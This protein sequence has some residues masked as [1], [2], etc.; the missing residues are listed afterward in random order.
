MLDVSQFD[1]FYVR[2]LGMLESEPLPNL[3]VLH[4]YACIITFLAQH[5]VNK[6]TQEVAVNLACFRDDELQKYFKM[7][8]LASIYTPKDT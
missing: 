5:S 4:T 8:F 3:V 1:L 6:I 2:K 7:S